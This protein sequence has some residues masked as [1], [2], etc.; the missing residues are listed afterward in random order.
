MT[1]SGQP[2]AVWDG[3]GSDAVK[4]ALG[5]VG[6]DF[7]NLLTPLMAYPGL[8]RAELADDS[9]GHDLLDAVER[10][11][12][13]MVRITRQMLQLSLTG[14]YAVQP[15]DLGDVADAAAETARRN[16]GAGAEVEFTL[17]APGDGMLDGGQDQIGQAI[18]RLCT[19]GFD[20][21]PDGGVLSVSTDYIEYNTS[22]TL[23]T[24]EIPAGAYGVVRVTDHGRGIDADT[25]PRVFEP[26]FTTKRDRA[27]RGAGLGL[28]YAYLV[29]VAHGGGVDIEQTRAPG[30]TTVALYLRA[31]SR[32]SAQ[33][34][35]GAA[36]AATPASEEACA[37]GHVLIVDDEESVRESFARV[38]SAS[39]PG[40][41][42][43]AAADG[44]E[45]VEA[46][47]DG[48]HA[49]VLMDIHMPRLDGFA[50]FSEIQGICR[51]KSWEPPSVIFCTGFAPADMVR[52]AVD[53][54]P[55]HTLLMKPIPGQALVEAVR[56][57]V[58][59]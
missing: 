4:Q 39:L 21:M 20:A 46:F 1:D 22:R 14:D 9:K 6:H 45:A 57:R 49:V 2:K 47:Q 42:V 52:R 15:F 7:G 40:I 32:E 54:E 19:N 29:A 13:D 11:A 56:A 38:L 59:S 5:R 58:P 17:N 33:E 36:S 3:S 23:T 48:H 55:R 16:Y 35:P 50:A 30:G 53:G 10:A 34:A 27:K 28:T 43:S 44:A 31:T 37:A 24:G 26:F 8:I 18:D 12:E 41:V 51:G 25:V